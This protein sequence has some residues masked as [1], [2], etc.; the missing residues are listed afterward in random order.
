LVPSQHPDLLRIPLED[1]QPLPGP[2]L[3]SCL[4]RAG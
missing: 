3:A 4:W 2:R 1:F